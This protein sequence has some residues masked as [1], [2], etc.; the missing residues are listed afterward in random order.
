MSPRTL[1][2]VRSLLVALAFLLRPLQG[3]FAQQS[4]SAIPDAD[5][6]RRLM[7]TRA[8]DKKA[9]ALIAAVDHPGAA[10]WL[11]AVG[12][13]RKGKPLD[14]NSVFEIGSITKVFTGI[15]LADMVL[16]G[17]VKLD[18]PVAEL[19]PKDVRMPTRGGNVITLA[20]LSVQNS[21]LPRLPDNL[22]PKDMSNPY[23]DYTVAQMYEFLGKHA[24][25]RDPGAQY[26]YS[27]LGV[28][29]LGHALSLRA[30]KPYETLVR[31]R[32]L[33][34]L[35]MTSTAITLT[36]A[37]RARLAQGHDGNGTPVPLWDLPTLA[38]AGALRSTVADMRRF[39]AA[40]ASP[41][42]NQ[43]GRALKLSMEPRVTMNRSLTMGLG[44]HRIHMEGDTLIWHNGGT[45]GYHSFA[46][47][48]A[49]T[50]ASVVLLA[51][52]SQD[53]D[54]IAR[55][56]VLP[57]FPLVKYVLRTE[58][59][60]PADSLR[61]YVGTFRLAPTFAITITEENGAL[62][63][64]ATGQPKFPLFAEAMDRFFLRVVDAQIEFVR[65]STGR[66]NELI[67]VQNGARQR[68][69]RVP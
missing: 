30:G 27:N 42:D 13:E 50:K 46:G 3:A 39:I 56:L 34:P 40:A 4:A 63:L 6:L 17:E 18:Q 32:I 37:M 2:T 14:E 24:L 43:I 48:N 36:A 15:L 19:L 38:G 25:R 21:G 16:R 20:H 22:A 26:E 64:Q 60:L 61:G 10:P 66:V 29:L 12:E 55:H 68:A 31:E 41:P 5:A 8:D 44:W 7:Q 69:G 1:A 57:A 65:D 11:V 51:N 49:R 47:F 33:E 35:G 45:G 9:V 62:H 54:D 23:A 59:T 52:S 28:G 53:N 67:L 58:I